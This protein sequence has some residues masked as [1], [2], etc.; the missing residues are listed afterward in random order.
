MKYKKYSYL[1]VLILMLLIGINGVHAE[2][3]DCVAL[4]GSKSDPDSIR[5]LLN[6][7]L[8]YPKIIVPILVIVLGMVDF[9]KAVMASKEDE[10][11]KA[12]TTF[13]KR[14]LISVVIFL[15]PTIV[16]II[17]YLA[18]IV[19]VGFDTSCSLW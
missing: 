11:K 19:L 14:V 1:L 6:E 9:G 5:Y 7:V 12:Q 8:M 18:D 3:S 2:S 10:M 4:F 13:I 17:M 15:V 16:D